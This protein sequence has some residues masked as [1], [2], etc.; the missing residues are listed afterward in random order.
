M[1]TAHNHS[2][3]SSACDYKD[4]D[5]HTPTPWFTMP[6]NP[7]IFSGEE[8]EELAVCDVGNMKLPLET[9]HANAV[10]IVKCVNAHEGLKQ[11]L[12][13]AY[14]TILNGEKPEK[15]WFTEVEKALA[16][17]EGK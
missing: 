14:H 6:L 7:F 11:K 17:A 5:S 12:Y 9:K 10:Y 1:K 2:G 16:Q 8:G 13:E 15:W 4:K 3:C